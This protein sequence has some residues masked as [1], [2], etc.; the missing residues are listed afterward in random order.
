M[1]SDP[2]GLAVCE[3]IIKILGD[4]ATIEFI[5]GLNLLIH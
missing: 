5:Y 3:V 1:V 2:E 4:G